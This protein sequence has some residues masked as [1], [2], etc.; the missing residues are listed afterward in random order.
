MLVK[1]S[2]GFVT[3]PGGFGTLDEF[4]ETATL[5]QTEKMPRLP[6]V[7]MGTRYWVPLVQFARTTMLSEGTISEGELDFCFT[8]D[9]DVAIAHIQGS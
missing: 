9:P 8:D 1:Y 5:V 6:L 4:F 2:R 7:G 3:L